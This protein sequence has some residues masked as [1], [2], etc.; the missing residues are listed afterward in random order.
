MKTD[1]AET[2]HQVAVADKA[3][4]GRLDRVLADELTDLSRSRLKNL[5]ETGCISLSADSATGSATINDPSYRVKSGQIFVITVPTAAPAI[6]EPQDIALDIAHE[7]NDLLVINKPAGLVVHPA[8]GNSRGTLV[9]ALLAHC[10]DSLSGI[11]GVRRPGIIHRL[12]KDT[13]GLIVVAKNDLTHNDL[14]AQFKSRSIQRVYHALIWGRPRPTSGE[15]EGNIGRSPKNRKKMSIV[16]RG[17]KTALTRYRTLEPLGPAAS[18]VECRLATGRTHQI[19]VHMTH[20]G[21]AVIGDETYGGRLTPARRNMI[22]PEA[23]EAVETL[24]RQAL[25]AALLGFRHPKSGEEMLFERGFPP[26]LENLAK[27][28]APPPSGNL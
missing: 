22:G 7:D 24:G 15:I 3:A 17:G 11:G 14:S 18:L 10:G 28:L 1:D 13:S 5:I 2:V 19:R 8:P 6:P 26:E 27:L 12:D 4:G 9:N 25:H 23:A 20:L 16:E 21:H